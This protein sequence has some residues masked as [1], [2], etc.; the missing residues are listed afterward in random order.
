MIITAT[1]CLFPHFF[2]SEDEISQEE[3]HA[4][5]HPTHTAILETTIEQPTK[6]CTYVFGLLSVES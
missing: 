3:P 1:Y 6:M 2:F 4:K 5:Y